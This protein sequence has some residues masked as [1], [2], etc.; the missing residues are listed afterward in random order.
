MCDFFAIAIDFFAI[1]IGYW[2]TSICGIYLL[3]GI[4]SW[5]PALWLAN[6]QDEDVDVA[7]QKKI[8]IFYIYK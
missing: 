5:E 6:S 2:F 8:A 1:E 3:V 4:F 7:V